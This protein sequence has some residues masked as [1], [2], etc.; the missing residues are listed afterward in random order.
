[1]SLVEFAK[2]ETLN[3]SDFASFQ[4]IGSLEVDF[5]DKKAL[6]KLGL[7]TNDKARG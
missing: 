5:L 2:D 3:R 7:E 6:F 1:M 4:D